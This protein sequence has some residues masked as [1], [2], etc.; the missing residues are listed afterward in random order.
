MLRESVDR[1]DVD[2]R[3]S[4]MKICEVLR[5]ICVLLAAIEPGVSCSRMR[6]GPSNERSVFLGRVSVQFH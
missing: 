6:S 4:N 5:P 3:R 1:D 2:A